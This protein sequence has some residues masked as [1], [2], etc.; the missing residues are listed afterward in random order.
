MAELPQSVSWCPF[1]PLL[2]MHASWEQVYACFGKGS[3]GSV[4]V[5]WKEHHFAYPTHPIP[6]RYTFGCGAVLL[7][8]FGQVGLSQGFP[9]CGKAP[10]VGYLGT[11]TSIVSAWGEYLTHHILVILFHAGHVAQALGPFVLLICV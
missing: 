9:C 8:S 11:R 3:L 2:T 1:C 5:G 4:E 10:S 7:G 6:P